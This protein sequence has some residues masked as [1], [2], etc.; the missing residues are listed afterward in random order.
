MKTLL[1]LGGSLAALVLF[2]CAFIVLDINVLH[3]LPCL[4]IVIYST[5]VDSKLRRRENHVA[6]KGNG[7]IGSFNFNPFDSD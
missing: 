4:N 6:G 2:T 3:Y 7:N 5:A 1:L